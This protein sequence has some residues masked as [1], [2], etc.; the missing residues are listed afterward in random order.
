[1]ITCLR[2]QQLREK[3]LAASQLVTERLLLQL[4]THALTT[5][6]ANPKRNREIESCQRKTC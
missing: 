3:A 4:V 1:M 6:L 5:V 2:A